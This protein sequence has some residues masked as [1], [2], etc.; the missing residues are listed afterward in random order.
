MTSTLRTLLDRVEQGEGRDEELDVRLVAAFFAPNDSQVM[1]SPINGVWCIFDGTD[2]NGRPRIWEKRPLGYQPSPTSSIDAAVA[3]ADKV[4]P[5]WA[6][7]VSSEPPVHGKSWHASVS[8]V[9]FGIP[10]AAEE[11]SEAT[12]VGEASYVPGGPA[13]ALVAALLRAKIAQEGDQ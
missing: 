3:L 1:Q 10:G 9:G 12:I 6:W 11:A 5:G 13:R 2:R 7:G 4:L 8:N